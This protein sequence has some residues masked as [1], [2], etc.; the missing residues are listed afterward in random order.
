MKKP[1]ARPPRKMRK[2][3]GVPKKSTAS[4]LSAVEFDKDIEKALLRN[5]G[6]TLAVDNR[7]LIDSA[8]ESEVEVDRIVNHQLKSFDD[9][10]D[11]LLNL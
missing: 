3:K 6:P 7:L 5:E 8:S 11:N 1:T 2:D 4:E 10:I 9:E